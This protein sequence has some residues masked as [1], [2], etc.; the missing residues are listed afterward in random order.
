MSSIRIGGGDTRAAAHELSVA[1]EEIFG[2]KLDRVTTPP[3][4]DEFRGIAETALIVLALPPALISSAD[5]VARAR[6]AERLGKLMERIKSIQAR[7]KSS[8]L[9]DPGNGKHIPL[10][11]ASRDAIIAALVKVER[12]LKGIRNHK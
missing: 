10:E 7:T 11:E 5:I 8:I 6:V 9:I 3:S 2:Q 4:Q 1:I 12:R